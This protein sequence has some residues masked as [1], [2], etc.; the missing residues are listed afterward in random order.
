MV[1]LFWPMLC[2]PNCKMEMFREMV[3]FLRTLSVNRGQFSM[4]ECRRMKNK[5]MISHQPWLVHN[6]S[7]TS[8]WGDRSQRIT[9]SRL[10]WATSKGL[11]LSIICLSVNISIIYL[12]LFNLPIIYLS[13][14]CYFYKVRLVGYSC[15]Y[16]LK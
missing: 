14:V 9:S 6:N 15:N 11:F 8:T 10:A 12:H 7:H 3:M 5:K 4:S 2:A 1:V 13:T 16:F